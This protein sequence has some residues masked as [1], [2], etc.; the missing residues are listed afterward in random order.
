MAYSLEIAQLR[1]TKTQFEASNPTPASGQL[2]IETDTD[3]S[4]VGDGVSTYLNIRGN[5][6]L[7]G[8]ERRSAD[9]VYSAQVLG[10][11][12]DEAGEG[13]TVAPTERTGATIAFDTPAIYN[14]PTSP[15]S[16][17]VSLDLS[18]AVAGTE[19]VAYFNHSAEPTWPAGVTAV[20]G[21]NNSALNVVRFLYQDSDDISAVIVSDAVSVT[22]GWIAINKAAPESRSST[23]TLTADTDLQ[24]PMEANKKYRFRAV[25]WIGSGSSTPGFKY[26]FTGPASPTLVRCNRWHLSS[27]TAPANAVVSAYD[28]TGLAFTGSLIPA[29]VELEGLVENGANAGNFQ[30]TWAQNTSNANTVGVSRNSYLEYKEII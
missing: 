30:I 6:A 11:G 17:S 5:Y 28:T 3:V 29:T 16:A 12:R 15:S 13:G 7:S 21:W 18:G 26:G 25:L 9:D 8:V 24:F 1:Y 23:T 22:N 4:T 20:G 27:G 2:C 19:V 10:D 14:S